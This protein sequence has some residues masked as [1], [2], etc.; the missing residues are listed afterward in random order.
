MDVV[1]SALKN[2][3][4]MYVTKNVGNTTR[5]TPK[6]FWK[7]CYSAARQSRSMAFTADNPC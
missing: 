5:Y 3:R 1:K 6:Q 2:Y 7:L 4:A